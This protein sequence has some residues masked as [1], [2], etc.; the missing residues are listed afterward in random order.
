MTDRQ[1]QT[2]GWAMKNTDWFLA[3]R[4]TSHPRNSSVTLET[5]KTFLGHALPPDK[6]AA[7]IAGDFP[8]SVRG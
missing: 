1:A 5:L 4:P 6:A 3:L 2:M 7:Q 8:E